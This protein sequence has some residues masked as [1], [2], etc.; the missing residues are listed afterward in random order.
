MWTLIVITALGVSTP[1]AQYHRYIDCYA[2][3]S[4]K[5]ITSTSGSKDK[6]DCVYVQR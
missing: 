6:F 4:I 1:I 5:R 3:A 2:E